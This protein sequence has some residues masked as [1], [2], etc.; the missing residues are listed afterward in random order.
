MVRV[1]AGEIEKWKT[2]QSKYNSSAPVMG[3]AQNNADIISGVFTNVQDVQVP[4]LDQPVQTTAQ[5]PAQPVQTEQIVQQ[6][7]PVSPFI[8]MEGKTNLSVEPQASNGQLMDTDIA[9]QVIGLPSDSST[10]DPV[11]PDVNPLPDTNIFASVNMPMQDTGLTENIENSNSAQLTVPYQEPVMTNISAVNVMSEEMFVKWI[12]SL[13]DSFTTFYNDINA[14]LDK[15]QE[16]IVEK[17]GVS[18]ISGVSDEKVVTPSNETTVSEVSEVVTPSITDVATMP[19]AGSENIFDLAPQASQQNVPQQTNFD[20]T[21]VI[22]RNV[23]DNAI[24]EMQNG[25]SKAA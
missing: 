20:E 22:P 1:I 25:M 16:Q 14:E 23:M 3:A 5:Q 17:S 12:N 21:M 4:N 6:T 24:M 15:I 10:K 9:N 11:I 7:T 18:L 13:R 2:L 8:D 19:I